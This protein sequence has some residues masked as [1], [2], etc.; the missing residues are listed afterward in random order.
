ME[1]FG[2]SAPADGLFEHFGIT[3]DTIVKML[4]TGWTPNY[5]EGLDGYEVCNYRIWAYGRLTLELY[6]KAK[7]KT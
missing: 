3:V 2:A 5:P 1:S 7:E 4:K 6:L